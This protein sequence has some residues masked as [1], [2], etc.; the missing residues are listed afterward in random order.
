MRMGA[1][2]L[3]HVLRSNLHRSMGFISLARLNWS[4]KKIDRQQIA[5][6]NAEWRELSSRRIDHGND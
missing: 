4:N 1:E 6:L 5:L 2:Q 3:G